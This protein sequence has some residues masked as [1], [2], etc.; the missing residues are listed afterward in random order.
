[1]REFSLIF[2]STQLSY[3]FSHNLSF[4]F[5]L[6]LFNTLSINIPQH[7]SILSIFELPMCHSTLDRRSIRNES[8]EECGPSFGNKTVFFGSQQRRTSF[9]ERNTSQN[10]IKCAAP[11]FVRSA[12]DF[13]PS[14]WPICLLH[15]QHEEP[16]RREMYQYPF[17]G[18]EESPHMQG[19]LMNKYF[20]IWT[21]AS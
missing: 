12:F 21:V 9:S 11:N 7:F 13:C 8:T 10:C 4:L 15:S 19:A 16:L 20:Y 6:S 2:R 1:M 3:W 5:S 17:S 18:L 14:C